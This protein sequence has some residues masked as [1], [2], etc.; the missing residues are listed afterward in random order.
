[1][2]PSQKIV[3][4]L[5]F[6]VTEIPTIK[7]Y[8]FHNTFLYIAFGSQSLVKLTSDQTGSDTKWRTGEGNQRG[9]ECQSIKILQENSAYILK[10]I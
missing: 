1:M 4:S 6:P 9:D 8:K 2:T 3:V 5:I 7:N 10:Q